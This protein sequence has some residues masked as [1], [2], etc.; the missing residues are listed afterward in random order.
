MSRSA[1]TLVALLCFALSA[2]PARAGVT[3]ETTGAA[4]R[5]DRMLPESVTLAD[6]RILVVGGLSSAGGSFTTSAEIYDPVA[7]TWSH[8]GGMTSSRLFFTLTR[9][10][11]GKVLAAGGGPTDAELYD[12]ATEGWTSAG[13]MSAERGGHVAVLLASGKVL[14]A[15]GV[16]GA[17]GVT[18]EIYDPAAPP[19]SAF[20]AADSM[21]VPRNFAAAARLADGSVL[22]AGG[23][24]TANGATERYLPAADS[25]VPADTLTIPAA[26]FGMEGAAPGL[27]VLDDGRALL[28]GP[29]VPATELYDPATDDWSPTGSME[30]PRVYGTLTKLTDG[31]VMLVGGA[32]FT[33]AG[34]PPVSE[35][36]TERYDPAVGEWTD[37]GE[38]SLGLLGHVAEALPGGR[39][40]VSHGTGSFNLAGVAFNRTT[41]IWPGKARLATPSAVAVG[42]A[43]VATESASVF[44][45]VR[46]EGQITAEIDAVTVSGA[47][48]SDFAVDATDCTRQPIDKGGQCFV[49]VNFT[50]GA[51]GPR[52]ATLQVVG[53]L[54][55]GQGTIALRGTGIPQSSLVGPAGP[56]GPAG[57]VKVTCK[58]KPAKKG[59][60]KTK[61]ICKVKN[62]PA[63]TARLMRGGR[64]YARGSARRLVAS[65][66]VRPGLYTLRIGSSRIRVRI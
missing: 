12:P 57:K 35:A 36:S 16:S 14:L 20:T 50:P 53:N 58:V 37:A 45:P 42:S 26:G 52:A 11:N 61:V 66:T 39:L 1:A 28:A 59:S 10:Q 17:A 40:M 24:A 34:A 49:M 8:T 55:A 63:T 22:V 7:G 4:T 25:W 18:A 64:T 15:G 41:Q 54:H 38:T 48:A 5:A 60:R 19:A 13:D 56:R 32:L 21:S 65:R 33:G 51:A 44:V 46:L 43:P 27:V 6:G 30:V 2:S 47:N 9:L 31:T 62:A 3:F 23:D 29:A